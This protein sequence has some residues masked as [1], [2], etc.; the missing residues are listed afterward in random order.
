MANK[1]EETPDILGDVLGSEEGDEESV[2][3]ATA[4]DEPREEKGREEETDSNGEEGGA[5]RTNNS[6]GEAKRKATYY[7]HED[8]LSDLEEVWFRL[9][10]QADKGEKR[11][12]SK[13]AIV[14]AAI[15]AAVDDLKS[16]EEGSTIIRQLLG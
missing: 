2:E 4:A 12:V 8:T 1:R 11:K 16:D 10:Q 15:E 6:S 7:L 13:S 14:E 3:T 5:D 9:R